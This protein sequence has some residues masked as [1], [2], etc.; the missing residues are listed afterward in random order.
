[1]P[2]KLRNRELVPTE[3]LLPEQTLVLLVLAVADCGLGE[4]LEGDLGGNVGAREGRA[5][6]A[7]TL[8]NDVGEDVDVRSVHVDALDERDGLG[9]GCD[10]A[11]DSVERLGKDWDA[12]A[13]VSSGG[14]QSRGV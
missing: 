4:A 13:E 7:Q 11:L 14:T 3:Q 12:S 1:M 6:D 9:P 2:S 8:L 10:V 5:R